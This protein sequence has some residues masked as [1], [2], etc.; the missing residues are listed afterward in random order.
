MLR[1][2]PSGAY[3][4]GS[5]VLGSGYDLPLRT[6]IDMSVSITMTVIF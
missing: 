1:T 4:F 5:E 3:G 2:P 6:S